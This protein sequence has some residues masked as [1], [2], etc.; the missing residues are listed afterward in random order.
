MNSLTGLS[1]LIGVLISSVLLSWV[2]SKD[3][4]ASNP[5]A[6]NVYRAPAPCVPLPTNFSRVSTGASAKGP[7]TDANVSNG[8]YCYYV[9][10]V[11]SGV[12]SLPSATAQIAILH[13]PASPTGLSAQ[14]LGSPGDGGGTGTPPPVGSACGSTGTYPSVVPADQS[15]C[16]AVGAFPAAP[17]S[18]TSTSSC[19]T[20]SGN[21]NYQLAANTGTE[22]SLCYTITGPNTVLDL[23]GKTLSGFIN[24]Q[25]ASG[26]HIYSSSAGAVHNCNYGVDTS[27]ACIWGG[28]V[29]NYTAAMNAVMEIDHF[30]IHNKDTTT[31][32]G[33]RNLFF[34]FYTT[35]CGTIPCGTVN[36]KIHHLT[37]LAGTGTGS[38]RI[39]NL[40]IQGNNA[41][42]EFNNN[43]TTCYTN[44]A[45]CQGIV[46][47]GTYDAK[48]HNNKLVN[49]QSNPLN[50]DTHRA[51]IC[52]Q[53][54]GCEIYSNYI[55]VQD[56]RCFRFR[57][58]HNTHDVNSSHDNYCDNV[59]SGSNGNYIAAIHLGD[60]DTGS[61]VENVTINHN[62][63]NLTQGTLIM[64]RD[65]TSI[66]LQDN[67]VNTVGTCANCLIAN[68]RFGTVA[69]GAS[70]LRTTINGTFTASPQNSCDPGVT[71][72][73]CKSGTG[74]ASCTVNN[75]AC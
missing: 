27:E 16:G 32:D 9:T 11:L 45:A 68:F 15:G 28:N 10:E 44:S 54:L 64:A 75:G 5:G 35:P 37:S 42:P 23:N 52:D 31:T 33:P 55:D 71:S 53:T 39:V 50:S 66:T 6:V 73:I 46:A 51:V 34:D 20:L 59:I 3:S 2:P 56:G 17:V 7:F 65:A 4:T 48:I 30:T 57:G 43:I 38:N 62:I 8:T 19:G 26:V 70:L 61:E 12:E 36:I 25:N 49:Q 22:T 67:T 40:Q 14:D 63:L 69:T 74:S 58:S 29:A 1:A 13:A 72:L 24:V 41:Y 21:T 47:F 18:P 60:P